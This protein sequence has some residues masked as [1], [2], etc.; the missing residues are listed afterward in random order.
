[1]SNFL[2]QRKKYL[3]PALLFAGIFFL[4]F[5]VLS[6]KVSVA[7]VVKGQECLPYRLWIIRKGVVPEKGK[8]VAFKNRNVGGSLTWVKMV[9]GVGGDWVEVVKLP[10]KLPLFV[11]DVG[12]EMKVRAVVFLRS[13]N[14]SWEVEAFEVFDKDT[15]GRPLP[16]IQGGKIPPGK[17]FVTSPAL[18]SYDSRYWGLIDEKDILG[19]A[20]PIF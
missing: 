9:S 2:S 17:F 15:K 12:R 6:S 3:F 8:Y 4:A 18:R 13:G 19:E 5:H 16:V 20:H 11:D 10:R 14:P 7:L 1:M